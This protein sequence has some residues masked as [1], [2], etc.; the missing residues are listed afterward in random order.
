MGNSMKFNEKFLKRNFNESSMNSKPATNNL[1][2]QEREYMI[3]TAMRR[4]GISNQWHDAVARGACYLQGDKYWMLVDC[5]MK[6][7]SPARYVVGAI[8]KELRKAGI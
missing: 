5:A 2:T 7:N 8:G 6:A 4:L 3:S 1:P